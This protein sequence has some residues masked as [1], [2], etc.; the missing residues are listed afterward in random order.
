[1][2]GDEDGRTD[3]GKQQELAPLDGGERLDRLQKLRDDLAESGSA[4]LP[5]PAE[6]DDDEPGE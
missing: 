3:E 2:A 6:E 4:T 5:A 1:M